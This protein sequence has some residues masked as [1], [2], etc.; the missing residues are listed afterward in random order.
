VE[1]NPMSLLMAEHKVIMGAKEVIEA[2]NDSWAT[3]G[4]V[5]EQVFLQLINFFRKYSDGFHHRKEEDQ[6][7]TELRN[8]PEFMLQSLI[9]ELEEHHESFREQVSKMEQSLTQKNYTLAQSQLSA[10]FNDLLDHISVEDE[11]LFVMSESLFDENVLERMYFRFKDIDQSLGE[12]SKQEL[13]DSI[14]KMKALL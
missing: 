6:L 7:F 2:M 8:H 13:E 10:Y 4:E 1:N 9:D 11:E 5:Y 12:S 14:A 3:S